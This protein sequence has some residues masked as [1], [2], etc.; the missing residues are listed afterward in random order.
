M[1]ASDTLAALMRALQAYFPSGPWNDDTER[2]WMLD[3]R[4]LEPDIAAEALKRLHATEET[5]FAPPWARVLSHV[6]AIRL[7]RRAKEEAERRALAPA[8]SELREQ[9]EA[10]L[11]LLREMRR[12]FP[13]RADGGTEHNH[14]D[15]IASCALCAKHDHSDT[16]PFGTTHVKVR[17]TE[18][19]REGVI[20]EMTH[21]EPVPAWW[22][23]CPACGDP[24]RAKLACST[25][26]DSYIDWRRSRGERV[27]PSEVF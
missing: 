21:R 16:R 14:R 15:G 27:Q 23:T 11:R 5:R 19:D 18:P 8:Q 17:G 12:A 10:S 22:F 20:H 25:V 4:T 3:L 9:R 24:D 26:T 2:V 6:H 7:E 13:R 1:T